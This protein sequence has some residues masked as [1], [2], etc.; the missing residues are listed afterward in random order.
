VRIELLSVTALLARAAAL[1]FV[2]AT[3][4]GVLPSAASARQ[5]TI[6]PQTGTTSEEFETVANT[7]QPGDTLVL[8]GGIYAQSAR[9]AVTCVGTAAA[10]IVIRSAPGES[11]LLTRPADTM[12]SQNNIELVGCSYLVLRDLR[13]QGGSCGMRIIGG[14]HVT[15]EGCEIF[16]TGNNAIAM[17]SGSGTYEGFVLRGNHIHHTGLSVS[18]TTEGEG[19]YLGCNDNA[20]RVANSLVEGN[21]IHH[22]RATSDGG[23]DGIEVKV[24]S[25]GNTIRNNVIHETNIGRQ[26]PGIFVYGG[27]PTVNIVEGNA[28]WNTGEAIQVVSDAIV[29]NNLCFNS[30]STGI[31]AAPHGQVP[32]MK[33]VTIV[34]NTI[35][36]NPEGIYVRWSGA[37]NMVLANNAIYS[38]ATAVNAGGLTGAAVTVKANYVGGAMSGAAL[39]NNAFFAGGT[40]SSAFVNPAGFDF[41]P[42][43]GSPLRGMAQAAYAPARDFNDTGRVSP[44]DVGAYELEGQTTNPGWKVGPGFKSGAP[45][46]SDRI[47][48]AP[49]SDLR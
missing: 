28:I 19:M 14:N 9:R 18:G 36:G 5:I 46:E 3:A 21:Y 29:R 49:T 33:N 6:L 23:N 15:I 7:L 42:R 4:A 30:S 41:W 37:S 32:T 45:S 38:S 25:Y 43:S 48:P 2:A 35:H 17:N 16:E 47:P 11:A 13:F 20:C 39:D 12:D 24:G 22:L 40:A 44:Y 26:Y 27:G 10:P 1:L 31:T 34:N 8:R